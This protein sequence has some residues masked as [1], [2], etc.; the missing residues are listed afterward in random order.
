MA[1]VDALSRSPT[2]NISILSVNVTEDDW[3]LSAQLQDENCRT[4]IETL[5]RPSKSGGYKQAHIRITAFAMDDYIKL[6][7]VVLSG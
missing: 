5:S 3:V 7:V 2:E 6:Q 1:H 4:L